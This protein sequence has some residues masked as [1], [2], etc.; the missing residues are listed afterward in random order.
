MGVLANWFQPRTA[1]TELWIWAPASRH[2]QARSPFEGHFL[3]SLLLS[4]MCEYKRRFPVNK[5]IKQAGSRAG[6]S[7]HSAHSPISSV[8]MSTPVYP[9]D[10]S[11]PGR[12]LQSPQAQNA[13]ARQGTRLPPTPAVETHRHAP[14][15]GKREPQGPGQDMGPVH[16]RGTEP[17][18][19]WLG[20]E[21]ES[22]AA[23]ESRV[24]W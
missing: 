11:E 8:P 14:S 6:T 22:R 5:D 4:K 18:P 1:V 7:S 3:R 17:P 10:L 19:K 12:T 20:W 13:L 2:S 23:W 9:C 24:H 21:L 16:R 15:P